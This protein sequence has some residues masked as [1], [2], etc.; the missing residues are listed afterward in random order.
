V[1]ARA[2]SPGK[3]KTRLIPL[4]GPQGAAEFQAAL[5]ADALHK[6]NRLSGRVSPY[7]F[8]A[9]KKFPPGSTGSSPDTSN[10]TVMCQ[11]G[12]GL[13]ARLANAFRELLPRHAAVV[14]IGT[15]SPTLPPRVLRAALRELRWC[16]AV[17][18]PCPD[19]GYYLLGLRRFERGLLRGIRW[20]S[21]MAFGDTLRNFLRQGF[22]CSILE[23]F[24][25]VDRPADVE[26]LRREL[27][28]SPA[29]R[30]LASNTRRYLKS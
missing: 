30:R 25:D 6:V 13:G 22:S 7:L 15:D 1:F 18:G 17:L 16:D 4:L 9:G 12:A 29:A 2:P 10:Y 19:G 3:A 11:R 20:G 14:V 24:P 27:V 23:P 8:V 26:R 21:A 5:M 28:R